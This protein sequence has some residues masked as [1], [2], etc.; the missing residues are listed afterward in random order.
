MDSD[1]NSEEALIG[2]ALRLLFVKMKTR[3]VKRFIH[4]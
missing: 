1:P 4:S 3:T 2:G